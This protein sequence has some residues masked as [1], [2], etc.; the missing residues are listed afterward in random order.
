MTFSEALAEGDATTCPYYAEDLFAPEALRDPFGHYRRIR[1]L[2]PV[3]RLAR[4]DV[5][6]LGRY[7]DV[8]QALLND[9]ALVS[10]QGIGFNEPFNAAPPEPPLIQRDG[11]RHRALRSVVLRNLTPSALRQHRAL[12]KAIIVRRVQEVIGGPTVE[13]VAALAQRLP[14]EAVTHLVGLP[15]EGRERMLDWASAGFNAIGPLDTSE[16]RAEMDRD[17]SLFV[18][19]RAYLQSV[20]RARLAKGSWT[21]SLLD[22]VDAGDLTP[23]EARAAMSAYVIPSLDTTI[24]AATNLLYNIGRDPDQFDRLKSDPS[25]IPGAVLEGV[26]HSATVRWFARVAVEDYPVG[27][28]TIPAGSRVM[29][30]YGS[31]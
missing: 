11:E 8:R 5:F 1:D 30:L 22:A 16:A 6:V 2:A 27:G 28:L 13:A 14:L 17:F 23:G 19:A 24:Y 31:G 29:L 25:L 4:P 21:A 20:D 18:E 15:E 10:G 3:V 26:R 7:K 12:L 9:R